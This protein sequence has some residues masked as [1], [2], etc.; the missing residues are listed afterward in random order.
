MEVSAVFQNRQV[1]GRIDLVIGGEGGQETLIDFKSGRKPDAL[2]EGELYPD[3]RSRNVDGLPVRALETDDRF[4]ELRTY[5]LLLAARTASS[6]RQLE[7]WYLS[8]PE[9]ETS[10]A[11][12]VARK[13]HKGIVRRLLHELDVA[14]DSGVWAA[15]QGPHCRR[16]P[17]RSAC[18]LSRGSDA[19]R[20]LEAYEM[21]LREAGLEQIGHRNVRVFNMSR[22]D[23]FNAEVIRYSAQVDDATSDGRAWDTS[24]YRRYVYSPERGGWIDKQ[25]TATGREPHVW[26][27]RQARDREAGH[28]RERLR[29]LER[30]GSASSGSERDSMR[31]E[32]KIRRSILQAAISEGPLPR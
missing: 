32:W 23:E 21:T 22:S 24:N 7:L 13:V 1:N 17:V 19:T 25:V 27:E 31:R 16:C 14:E 28:Q 9:D 15:R 8:T 18:P 3:V 26:N 12:N 2:A 6:A 20:V 11:A 29:T 30:M 10:V 4:F 5:D